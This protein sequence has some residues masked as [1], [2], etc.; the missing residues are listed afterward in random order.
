MFVKIFLFAWWKYFRERLKCFSN[1]SAMQPNSNEMLRHDDCGGRV[2]TFLQRVSERELFFSKMANSRVRPFVLVAVD[3]VGDWS[4][5]D[6]STLTLINIAL[7]TTNFLSTSINSPIFHLYV[8]CTAAVG[9]RALVCSQ[10]YKHMEAFWP[11][12]TINGARS[13]TLVEAIRGNVEARRRSTV[14]QLTPRVFQFP[15]HIE[16]ERA[17][18]SERSI[19]LMLYLYFVFHVASQ[20]SFGQQIVNTRLASSEHFSRALFCA[21]HIGRTQ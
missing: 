5:H 7:A 6:E 20:L 13:S 17:S 12:P 19:R 10:L 3:L 15:R 4:A 11:S 1:S 18:K 8:F 2:V 14:T 9:W 21:F 16:S